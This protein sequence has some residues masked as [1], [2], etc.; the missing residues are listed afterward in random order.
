MKRNK[1]SVDVSDRIF[2]NFLG[3][4]NW[5]LAVEVYENDE[6][7]KPLKGRFGGKYEV[8]TR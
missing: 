7:A 1:S 5:Q 2:S 6:K 4:K 3:E 8:M